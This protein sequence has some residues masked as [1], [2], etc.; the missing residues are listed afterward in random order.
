MFAV[1]VQMSLYER[2]TE[3]TGYVPKIKRTYAEQIST[4]SECQKAEH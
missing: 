3:N 4:S 1:P 2:S